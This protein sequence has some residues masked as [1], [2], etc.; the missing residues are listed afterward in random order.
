MLLKCGFSQGLVNVYGD[1]ITKIR[2]EHL[3]WTVKLPAEHT[4]FSYSKLGFARDNGDMGASV[5][6]SLGF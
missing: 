2:L 1:F 6:F 5:K 3:P 4:K